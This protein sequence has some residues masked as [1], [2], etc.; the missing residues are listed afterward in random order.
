MCI[1]PDR[2]P[3]TR[4][5]H[6][7]VGAAGWRANAVGYVLAGD[8]DDGGRRRA[9]RERAHIGRR[10][11]TVASAA[12]ATRQLGGWRSERGRRDAGVG[13]CT[14]TNR[15]MSRTLPE[16]RTTECEVAC[17]MPSLEEATP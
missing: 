5:G 7:T 6:G 14:R 16:R 1:V 12:T 9:G 11:S 10:T 17:R 3:G 15:V 13:A 4:V 2:E 8:G